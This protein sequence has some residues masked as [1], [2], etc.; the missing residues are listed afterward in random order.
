MI[1]QYGSTHASYEPGNEIEVGIGEYDPAFENTVFGLK[2]VGDISEPFATGYGYN[3]IRLA[4]IE[5]VNKD[6]NDVISRAHLQ[7]KVEQDHRLSA[8]KDHLLGKWLQQTKYTP[9]HY[10]SADLWAFTDTVV[11][12]GKNLSTFKG[13]SKQTVLFSFAREKVTVADWFGFYLQAVQSGAPYAHRDYPSIMQEFIK[14]SCGNYYRSHIEDFYPALAT[15]LKEFNEANLLF[16][17][18]DRHVWSKASDDT[19]GLK[20]Y[21]LQHKDRYI[22]QPGVSALV[23]SSGSKQ[24]IDSIA[25]QLPKAADNW[26]DLISRYTNTAVADSSRFENGQLPVKQPVPMQKGFISQPEL[27]EAGDAYTVVYVFEVHHDKQPRSFDDARGLVIND[28]QQQLEQQ[29][30]AGLKKKYPVKV[31]DAVVKNL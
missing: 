16:A 29:W 27:N 21:Y 31:N 25:A 7:E 4:G 2:N 14:T 26:R 1:Q 20:N 8:A 22:W 11:R 3:I 12:K 10:N 24:V 6:E 23:V 13:L 28:Y 17:V 15:Q 5:P 18:M 30:L 9:A 19:V